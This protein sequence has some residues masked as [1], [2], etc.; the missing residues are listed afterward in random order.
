MANV[1]YVVDQIVVN[2]SEGPGHEGRR[3][4]HWLGRS[5]K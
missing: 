1:D 4:D 5:T 2:G 3:S